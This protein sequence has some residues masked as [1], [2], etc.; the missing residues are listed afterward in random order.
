MVI[1]GENLY[2][3]GD[4]LNDFQFGNLTAMSV[5]GSVDGL[6][7]K[8]TDSELSVSN[9]VAVSQHVPVYPNPTFGPVYFQ[10]KNDIE[11]VSLYDISGKRIALPY[12]ASEKTINLSSLSKGV[13][14]LH[15]VVHGQTQVHKIIKK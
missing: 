2:C 5:G 11:N 7:V 12:I 4:F 10:S 9:P 14:F 13:Y 3:S 1:A 6:V 8:F 15:T